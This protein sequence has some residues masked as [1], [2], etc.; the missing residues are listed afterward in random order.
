MDQIHSGKKPGV[1]ESEN[2]LDFMLNG[3]KRK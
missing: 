2:L 3:D 1:R